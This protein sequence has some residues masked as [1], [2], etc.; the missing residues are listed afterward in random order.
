MYIRIILVV[1]SIVQNISHR[2]NNRKLV[3]LILVSGNKLGDRRK[4]KNKAM[5][6]KDN[7]H[8][9]LKDNKHIFLH[10]T[11]ISTI[12]IPIVVTLNPL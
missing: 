11:Q 3:T 6:Q 1:L 9:L 12:L 10:P 4:Y 7:N 2:K 8:I 5:V